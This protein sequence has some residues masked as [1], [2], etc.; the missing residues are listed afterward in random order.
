MRGPALVCRSYYS[1]LRAPASIERLAQAVK[2]AGYAA[3]AIADVNSLYGATELFK[4]APRFDL[5][6]ILGVEIFTETQDAIFLAENRKG[7]SNLCRIT[8]A[9]NLKKAFDLN[10]EFLSCP[11]GII[12]ISQDYDLLASMSPAPGRNVFALCRNAS[13]ESKAARDGYEPLACDVFSVLDDNDAAVA[14]LLDRIRQM[15][16]AGPGPKDRAGNNTLPAYDEFCHRF[17]GRKRAIRNAI[18]IMNRCEMD[19]F[20]GC[21]FL[22]EVPLKRGRTSAVEL[23]RLC[24]QGLARKFRPVKREV[25]KRLERELSVIEH[26]RFS[27]YFLVVQRIVDFARSRGIPVDVRGS[28]AGSLVSYVLGFTRVDPVKHGLYFE[29]FMNAGRSDCPDID[30][31]LCWR[32]R[33]EVIQFCY[34][35]WG[36]DHVAMICTINRYRMKGAIRDVGRFLTLAPT[37]VN[38]LVRRRREDSRCAV[39]QLAARLVDIPRHIGIHCGGIVITPQPIAELAPLEMATKGIVVTQYDKHAAEDAGFIKIDLLGNRSLSTVADAVRLVN[40]NRDPVDIDAI[41]REDA[42]AAS[43]LTEGDSLGVFQCESPSM[44]QLLRGMKIRNMNDAGIALS[45]I[46][47]GPAAGGSKAEFIARHIGRK[48]FEYMHPRMKDLLNDTYGVMLYQEDV[49]RIAVEVAG[50]TVEEADQ[51]RSEVSTKVSPESIHRQY[52]DFVYNRAPNAGI[53]RSTA[54]AIWND[55]LRFA[56]YSYCKAHAMVYANIAWQTAYLKAHYP[57][58]FYTSLLNNHHGMYPLRVYV[59]DAIRHGIGVM[60][61]H[62]NASDIEWSLEDSSIRAG[63][64]IVKGLSH[65]TICR[66]LEER[67]SRPF[68]HLDDFRLRV[69]PVL[70]ELKDLIHLGAC[71]GLGTT[72]P[73][74]LMNADF[75]PADRNQKLLFQL[76][77]MPLRSELPD[78]DNIARMGAEMDCTGIP[79]SLHPAALIERPHTPASRL[80]EYVGKDVT[81]AGL[82]ATARLAATGDGRLMGFMTIEDSSGLA[83]LTFFPDQIADYRHLAATPGPLWVKGRVQMHL[84]SATIEYRKGGTIQMRA[85][86]DSP[87]QQPQN[88]AA[89]S[90]NGRPIISY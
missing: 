20:S 44:R 57:T 6:P 68:T 7:Y 15:S 36:H 42:S 69:K 80:G 60:P 64:G 87:A 35:H 40:H 78:Y 49:M 39:Y 13:D 9:V 53:D 65:R 59:W 17:T 48:H 41:D 38:E 74:M 25:V 14:H 62:V 11:E 29:R 26:G 24:H 56:A 30:I 46:R 19:L 5:R 83:E 34:D 3:I 67:S 71:D 82:P 89:A 8:G 10:N 21:V 81:V 1:L 58:E 77:R 47:P 45:L 54:E 63:L 85:A 33:D 75:E 4:I 66:I 12:C 2:S 31:D 61:P 52:T 70:R 28:A 23:S 84:D 32:R 76:H 72:R 90:P 16:V 37:H 22:P 43:M 27:G 79:F 18:D 55:I 88:A 86:S 73:A 50:Y 51:F